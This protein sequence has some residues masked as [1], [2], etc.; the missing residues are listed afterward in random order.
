M[1]TYGD[2]CAGVCFLSTANIVFRAER[3]TAT[4]CLLSAAYWLT[5]SVVFWRA[6]AVKD[7]TLLEQGAVVCHCTSCLPM[8][9]RIGP[10]GICWPRK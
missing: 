3:D 8:W 1:V 6:K 10:C 7:Q 2:V 4:S 5:H 9:G